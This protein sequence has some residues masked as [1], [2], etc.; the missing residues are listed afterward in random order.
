MHRYDVVILGAGSAGTLLATLLVEQG[1][2]VAL[3]E[4]RLVGGDCPYLACMPSKSLLRSAAVR[5]LLS[6]AGELGASAAPQ[7]PDD[8]AAAYAAAVARRDEVADHRDDAAYA[9]EM[10]K[11]GVHL[12]RGHGEITGRGTLAVHGSDDGELGWGDLVVATGSRPVRPPIEGLDA[13]PSWTSDEALSSPER[14][15]SLA[16]LGGG[17]VGCELAQVYAAFGSAVTLIEPEGQLLAGQEPEVSA[18]VLD[19][20]E[21]DGIDVRLG[22]RAERAEVGAGG[23]GARLSLGGGVSVE[24]DR[25]LLATGREPAVRGLGLER[26]GIDVDGSGL[27]VDDHGRVSGVQHVWAAGDVTGVAPYTHAANYQ[28]RVIAENLLGGDRRADYRAIPHAV[29]TIPPAAG[30]GRTRAQAEEAGIEAVSASMPMKETARAST[31]G[32]DAGALVLVADRRRRVLI[33]ASGFGGH[34]DEMIGEAT[35]AIRAEIPLEVLVD[36]VHAFPTF[37]EAYEPV[38]RDLLSQ[39]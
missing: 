15:R 27:E 29:Y 34:I 35:L 30:V 9:E 6:R 2:S 5:R 17:A 3:V 19:V 37:G 7:V 39:I 25:V 23:R 31:E 16:V 12:L 8:G 18:A 38:L 20:L 10:T 21:A 22:L 28:A 4:R 32:E 13:V 36:V 11:A 14:P 26:L 33:G 24:A 1:R